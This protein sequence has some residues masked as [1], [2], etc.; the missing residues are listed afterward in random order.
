[1]KIEIDVSGADIFHEN[2]TIC[3]SDCTGNIK[4]FKFSKDLINEL[5]KN[6]EKGKYNKCPYGPNQ[7]KFKVRI[8]RVVLRYLLKALFKRNKDKEVVVQFCRDFPSHEEGISQSIKYRIVK[9]HKRN[10]RR[11]F[12]LKLKKISDA[13]CYA[14]MMHN[15]KY[16]YLTCYVNISLKDI[17]HGLVF[18]TNNKNNK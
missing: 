12:C 14:L 16:N 6:W 1:M 7:G 13:H 15:D 17:E 2:Y 9:V 4:G 11:I 3:V 18:H 5:N 10:L 8:Y